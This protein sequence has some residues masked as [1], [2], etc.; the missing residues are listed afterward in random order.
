MI[1]ADQA[2][3]YTEKHATY[4][5]KISADTESFEYLVT[6]HLRMSGV[7]WGLTAMAL[8]GRD[9]KAEPSYAGMVDWILSCQD[10]DS[11][12]YVE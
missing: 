6:Q 8:L 2:S 1:A 12:G 3:F 9:L 5:Q 11:G 10:K 4:I 7:Y